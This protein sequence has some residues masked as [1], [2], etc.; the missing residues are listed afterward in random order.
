MPIVNAALLF[1][2]SAQGLCRPASIPQMLLDFEK[3][4]CTFETIFFL[5]VH[6]ECRE[7]RSASA[8]PKRCGAW[9]KKKQR[10]IATATWGRGLSQPSTSALALLSSLRPLGTV[11]VMIVGA[12]CG[13]DE[14]TKA[15]TAAVALR[16]IQRMYSP[17]LL[18][19][20]QRISR[21]H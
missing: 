7:K 16:Q 9:K 12:I 2:P 8:R 19:V 14:D 20:G 1:I 10:K 17:T 15:H 11:V 4:T 18:R 6:K 13:G 3:E 21:I 5:W